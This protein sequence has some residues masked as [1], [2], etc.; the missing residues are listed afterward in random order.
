M[1]AAVLS[2]GTEL[3]R[4]ELTN[5]NA[6]WLGDRLTALGFS[7]LEH[8]S[9]DDDEERIVETLKRLC[10][11]VQVVVCTGGLGPTTD[12]LT[13]VAVARAVG[14]GLVRD[15]ASL[16]QIRRKWEARG[17]EMPPSNEKQ[18]DFPEGADIL[19]NPVGTAPGFAVSVGRAKAFFM[20]GVP[21]EMEGM[22]LDSVRPAIGALA[23]R[24]THQIHVRTFGLTESQ[25]QEQLNGVEAAHPGITLGYRAS[26]P[27]IEVKI[28]AQSETGVDAEKLAR[29]GAEDVRARLG[30]VVYGDRTDTYPD[31]VGR[32]LRRQ[33]L[34]LSVAESCTGGLIGAML[35]SVPG[36]SDYLL[37]DAVTYSNSSKTAV[38][39]VSERL[40]IAH[41]AVSG[42]V[43]AAMAEGARRVSD[44]DI[45]VSVTGIAGPGGG[46]EEKPVGTVWFGLATKDGATITK[47]RRLFGDRERI[48]ILSAYVALRMVRRAALGADLTE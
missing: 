32:A 10:E 12:D 21:R 26:F 42:E 35:T 11:R 45:A 29:R 4:G 14:V 38:L 36:S 40:M 18:A 17:G 27:E 23:T 48:R 41:G 15:D 3:T 2:I 31:V 20:P 24:T 6:S 37:L 39:G 44:A 19:P 28:F 43:A 47:K 46:T 13:T 33:G 22:F 8:V 5:S 7:V 9:V 30:D 25:A 34:T 16:G 1:S